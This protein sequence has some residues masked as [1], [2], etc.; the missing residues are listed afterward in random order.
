MDVLEVEQGRK[1]YEQLRNEIIVDIVLAENDI[2]FTMLLP[3]NAREF[4]ENWK[5]LLAFQAI[6]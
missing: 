1:I 2:L 4:F 3:N 5:R 6:D